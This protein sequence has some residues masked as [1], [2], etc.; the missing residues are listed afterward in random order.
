MLSP[1]WLSVL[2]CTFTPT[3]F[4][5]NLP[6]LWFFCSPF[7]LLSSLMFFF[8]FCFCSM[9]I[10]RFG[11]QT[12][13]FFTLPK[14]SSRGWGILAFEPWY[15]SSSKNTGSCFSNNSTDRSFKIDLCCVKNVRNFPLFSPLTHPNDIISEIWWLWTPRHLLPAHPTTRRALVTCM[16]ASAFV[17][18]LY[19]CNNKSLTVR[20]CQWSISTFCMCKL[21]PLKPAQCPLR[22]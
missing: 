20:L 6:F 8:F 14:R 16:E 10:S 2:V 7:F 1:N 22:V 12:S 18:W 13:V 3:L 5:S 19:W 11:F 9:M 4:N 21:F 17:T 15:W